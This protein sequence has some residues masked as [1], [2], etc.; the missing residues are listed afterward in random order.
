MALSIPVTPF[1]GSVFRHIAGGTVNRD[2]LDFRWAGRQQGNRWNTPE[3]PTLYTAGELGVLIAE[4]GRSFRPGYPDEL[5]ANPSHRNVFRYQFRLEAVADLREP[6]ICDAL[7]M[8]DPP[9]RYLDT[10]VTSW[11]ASRLR[12]ETAAQ[13]I[14]VP[15]MAFLDDLSRWNL[16][17]FLEKVADDT[18]MWITAVTPG[19][20]LHWQ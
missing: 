9:H 18:T 11:T 13:A 17:V 3:Q 14:L 10:E 5:T 12:T 4:W 19:G 16:V 15:S 20:P 7:G 2:P 8:P 6:A 1:I